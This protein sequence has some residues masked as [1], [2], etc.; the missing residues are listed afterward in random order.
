MPLASERVVVVVSTF[1]S[2]CSTHLRGA[3]K[4]GIIVC[5]CVSKN[6]Q[7]DMVCV[8]RIENCLRVNGLP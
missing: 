3:E 2:C 8:P 6:K 4:C 7:G 1:F 5:V